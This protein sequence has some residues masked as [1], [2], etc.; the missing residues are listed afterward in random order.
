MI[1]NDQLSWNVTKGQLIYQDAVSTEI[2]FK[3]LF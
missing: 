3:K 1:L 2:I